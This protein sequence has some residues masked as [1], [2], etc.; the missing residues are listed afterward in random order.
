MEM[1]PD[2]RPMTGLSNSGSGR[3][4]TAHGALTPSKRDVLVRI[5]FSV[6]TDVETRIPLRVG[7][8]HMN[9]SRV[10][11]MKL[12]RDLGRSSLVHA[13]PHP[14]GVGKTSRPASGPV[15]VDETY[16]GGK[17]K[18]KHFE[19]APG[20]SKVAVVGVKH[21]I[22]SR[23]RSWK[24]RTPRRSR[25]SSA[26]EGGSRLSD[27]GAYSG[28]ENHE[29]VGVRGRDGPHERGVELLGDARRIPRDLPPMSP[30]HLQQLRERIRGAGTR[31]SRRGRDGRPAAHVP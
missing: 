10:L 26:P 2:E 4:S 23:P 12:H 9:A 25:G 21:R 17:E 22:R 18:N 14:Q 7:H 28:L 31:R 19:A 13:A 3:P 6:R 27:H 29:T 11:G 15:E 20:R 5:R 1:F 8:R 24:P 30:K 16:I